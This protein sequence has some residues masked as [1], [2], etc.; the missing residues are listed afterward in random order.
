[1]LEN[2]EIIE[3]Y[4]DELPYPARLMLAAPEQRPLHVVASDHSDSHKTVIITVYEPNPREWRDGFRRR[5]Q[6]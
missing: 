5:R 2:G 3:E 1:V 6:T 4:P